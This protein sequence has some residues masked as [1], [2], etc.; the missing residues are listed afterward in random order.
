[1]SDFA[2]VETIVGSQAIS[3]N[4]STQNHELGT[5]AKAKDGASTAYGEGEFIYLK[6]V[7]STVLG[8]F[9][10][11]NA[12]DFSSVLLVGNAVGPVAIAMSICVA[13]EFGWYQIQGKGVGKV[14]ASFADN[15]NCYSTASA[16]IVDDA[17]VAGDRVQRCKGASAIGT[18]STGLAEMEIDRPFVNNAL[19]D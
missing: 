11:Y 4:S 9:V 13:G 5:I 6:G 18:P 3:E 1:M 16:G 19:A 12:D 14:A 17:I 15:A 8:S 10:T 7:V 2:I